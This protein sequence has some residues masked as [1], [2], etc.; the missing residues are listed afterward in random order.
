MMDYS[1]I[2]PVYNCLPYLQACVGSIR[3]IGLSSWEVI[4]VD[5]GSTDGS[6]ILCDRLTDAHIRTVHQANQGVSASLH[7]GSFRILR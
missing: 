4:L 3:E 1:F 7:R 6:G 5:D 2:V